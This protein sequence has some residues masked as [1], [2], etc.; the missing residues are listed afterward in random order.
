MSAVRL[1][2]K[3]GIPLKFIREFEN[4][5]RKPLDFEIDLYCDVFNV[6]KGSILFFLE[7]SSAIKKHIQNYF[8]YVLEK[9]QDASGINF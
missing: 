1:S 8:L 6:Q 9:I 3:T 7:T 4:G 5:E 2:K